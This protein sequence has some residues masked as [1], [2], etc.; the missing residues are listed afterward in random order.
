MYI[1]AFLD[2]FNNIMYYEK[3]YNYFFERI[4]LYEENCK[5][6]S[7]ITDSFSSPD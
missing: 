4:D 5:G 3:E 1:V 6:D 2:F 7:Y